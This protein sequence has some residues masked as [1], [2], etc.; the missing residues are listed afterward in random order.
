L[1]DK[2]LALRPDR[3]AEVRWVFRLA[4]ENWSTPKIATAIG[5]G[6]NSKK[7][8]RVLKDSRVL[9][10]SYLGYTAPAIVSERA[11]LLA[12]TAVSN[13]RVGGKRVV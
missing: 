2:G 6:W 1:A 13:R 8:E 5:H 12:N 4:A 3:V 7:V 10:F 11:F 9:G